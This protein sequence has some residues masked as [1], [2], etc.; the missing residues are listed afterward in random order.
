[1]ELHLVF[2]GGV[3]HGDGRDWVAPFVVT[4]RYE[5]SDGHCHWTKRYVSRHDVYYDGFN[6]GKGI[7]GGWQIPGDSSASHVHGGFHIWPKGIAD[8]TASHLA[9]AADLEQAVE[10]EEPVPVFSGSEPE[11]VGP[12]L[13]LSAG[14]RSRHGC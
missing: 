9:A 12:C 11:A 8:P 7:W 2:R 6:E 10:T 13:T 5:I 1:M 3:I 14:T 4:G